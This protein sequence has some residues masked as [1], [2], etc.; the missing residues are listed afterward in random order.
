MAEKK[1]I[2]IAVN[3]DAQQSEQ[4]LDQLAKSL[5]QATNGIQSIVASFSAVGK[6]ID[7]V[8]GQ[9][10]KSLSAVG[11]SLQQVSLNQLDSKVAETTKKVAANADKAKQSIEGVNTV[12]LGQVAKEI[13]G[14]ARNLNTINFDQIKTGLQQVDAGFKVFNAQSIKRIIALGNALR[15]IQG[16]N[17]EQLQ[18]LERFT[19]LLRQ[20]EKALLDVQRLGSTNLILPQ[21]NQQTGKAQ[22]LVDVINI[23]KQLGT[24]SKDLQAQMQGINLQFIK[25]IDK[26]LKSLSPSTVT[27]FKNSLK[28]LNEVLE[29]ASKL[30]FTASTQG[31]GTEKFVAEVQRILNG[32][33]QIQVTPETMEKVRSIGQVMTLI[34]LV[35]RSSL[36]NGSSATPQSVDLQ[37]IINFVKATRSIPKV[38]PDKIQD[39]PTLVGHL[40][41][42]FDRINNLRLGTA[43]TFAQ[44]ADRLKDFNALVTRVKSIS[45]VTPNDYQRIQEVRDSTVL[46][47]DAL[48][49]VNNIVTRFFGASPKAIKIPSINIGKFDEAKADSLNRFVRSLETFSL[50]AARIGGSATAA[51]A[52][53]TAIAGGI[54]ALNEA[55][56]GVTEKRAAGIERLGD[57]IQEMSRGIMAAVNNA[58]AGGLNQAAAEIETSLA[59][60]G[61]A[62]QEYYSKANPRTNDP[63]NTVRQ[64]IDAFQQN[65]RRVRETYVQRNRRSATQTEPEGFLGS[66]IENVNDILPTRGPIVQ[67][68]GT[69]FLLQGAIFGIERA[70]ERLKTS[71]LG[72]NIELE[73]HIISLTTI[74][75]TM[76]KAQEVVRKFAIPFAAQVP[77]FE[78]DQIV[79]TVERLAAE[80]F[81]IGEITG[82]LEAGFNEFTGRF[83]NQ[84]EGSLVKLLGSAAVA[85]G[86]TLDQSTDA[87][88]S[89]IQ[90]RFVK[91]RRFGIDQGTLTQFGF[92]GNRE[93]REGLE[94]SLKQIY[95][96]RFGDLIKAQSK[97]FTG[98]VS[99]IADLLG[100][101]QRTLF[102]GVFRTVSSELQQV[103]DALSS[104]EAAFSLALTTE[105]E[106]A[107]GLEGLL[108]VPRQLAKNLKGLSNVF[109]DI[110]QVMVNTLKFIAEYRYEF[111]VGIFVP[112]A[113]LFNNFLTYMSQRLIESLLNFAGLF[114]KQ[115]K[116]L[117]LPFAKPIQ[118]FREAL[119]G[120]EG[121][122]VN[123]KMTE[124]IVKSSTA[125]GGFTKQLKEVKTLQAGGLFGDLLNG[126]TRLTKGFKGI[127]LGFR[128]LGTAQK[129][130]SVFGQ[131]LRGIP[132]PTKPIVEMFKLLGQAPS[133]FKVLEVAWGHVITNIQR[134]VNGLFDRLFPLFQQLNNSK[135]TDALVNSFRGLEGA[136]QRMGLALS[137][138]SKALDAFWTAGNKTQGMLNALNRS[139]LINGQGIVTAFNGSVLGGW[140]TRLTTF[141]TR[142]NGFVGGFA[143]GIAAAFAGAGAALGRSGFIAQIFN[144]TKALIPLQA[145]SKALQGLSTVASGAFTILSSLLNVVGVALRGGMA[146]AGLAI[147]LAGSAFK[148]AL[149]PAVIDVILALRD[150]NA[151]LQTARTTALKQLIESI[152]TFA[153]AAENA[154]ISLKTAF[155]FFG[156]SEGGGAL[157][158]LKA[159]FNGLTKIANIIQDLQPAITI[160]VDALKA[161]LGFLIEAFAVLIN[162][163]SKVFGFFLPKDL[164]D[165]FNTLTENVRNFGKQLRDTT[166]DLE[167]LARQKI[168][169]AFLTQGF[170]GLRDAGG[171]RGLV[172][173]KG[174]KEEIDKSLAQYSQYA[175]NV[176]KSLNSRFTT[177]ASRDALNRDQGLA[178]QTE[179]TL[180]NALKELQQ[181]DTGKFAQ[182]FFSG[183]SDTIVSES[184]TFAQDNK[185]RNALTQATVALLQETIDLSAAKFKVSRNGQQLGPAEGLDLEALLLQAT[186]EE[187]AKAL[188]EELKKAFS[189]LEKNIKNL[190]TN[191]GVKKA[192]LDALKIDKQAAQQVI[193]EIVNITSAVTPAISNS[194][195]ATNQEIE[196]FAKTTNE[197]ATG[198][199][200]TFQSF[201][202]NISAL[203]QDLFRQSITDAPQENLDA[204]RRS[205]EAQTIKSFKA[206]GE[207]LRELS[208]MRGE[209]DLILQDVQRNQQELTQSSESILVE[210]I[211]SVSKVLSDSGIKQ[212]F[213]TFIQEAI[214]SSTPI[215]SDAMTKITQQLFD[216]VGVVQGDMILK[217][218]ASTLKGVSQAYA[219]S[220]GEIKI[221][222]KNIKKLQETVTNL[223]NIIIKT[224]DEIVRQT[225]TTLA[226]TDKMVKLGQLD[227]KTAFERINAARLLLETNQGLQQNEEAYLKTVEETYRAALDFIGLV[228]RDL[229]VGKALNITG[230]TA[231]L[232]QAAKVYRTI[233]D[234]VSQ[235]PKEA[236]NLD[237]WQDELNNSAKELLDTYN[238]VLD[239]QLQNRL[240]LIE[241]NK[242]L[243]DILR[244]RQ[245][246]AAIPE[247]VGV[248]SF[249]DIEQGAIASIEAA[250]AL[251]AARI[252]AE[253]LSVALEEQ[254][255]TAEQTLEIYQ[256][257]IESVASIGKTMGATGA[258]SE[259]IKDLQE[260]LA[261][262]LLPKIQAIQKGILDTQNRQRETEIN[263]NKEKERALQIIKQQR[264]LEGKMAQDRVSD[265]RAQQRFELAGLKAISGAD[266]SDAITRAFAVDELEALVQQVSS[267]TGR[268]RRETATELLERFREFREKGLL[269]PD[270]I[271]RFANIYKNLRQEFSSTNFAIEDQNEY[272]RLQRELEAV[273]LST[274]DLGNTFN[275]LTTEIESYNT[276]LNKITENSRNFLILFAKALGGQEDPAQTVR[277]S[278]TGDRNTS[279]TVRNLTNASEDQ[280]Y[281]EAF[282]QQTKFNQRET[283][284]GITQS[285]QRPLQTLATEF[286]RT[287]TQLNGAT[288]EMVGAVEKITNN[289]N[290]QQVVAEA[291]ASL[292]NA[293]NDVSQKVKTSQL[294]SAAE[295][296]QFYA[297]LET[298]P[299]EAAT[300]SMLSYAALEE[301]L[302]KAVLSANQQTQPQDNQA[303]LQSLENM[304]FLLS[305]LNQTAAQEKDTTIELSLDPAGL[306]SGTIESIL[307]NKLMEALRFNM[308]ATDIRNE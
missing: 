14:I 163:M 245:R 191:Q 108:P 63:L 117:Q 149:L 225:Q 282:S 119:V 240:E 286:E 84:F 300:E 64:N 183:L 217:D 48:T 279:N 156:E 132:V 272:I 214:Q 107:K 126:F 85:F 123:T 138:G 115:T 262:D 34:D 281:N 203:R 293:L 170:S 18:S 155:G 278:L 129:L 303:M 200:K 233:R 134:S 61:N 45:R 148:F 253:D 53:V 158:F 30:E 159:F 182:S 52:S 62:I 206:R 28:Q 298:N 185:T 166:K 109:Q 25:D 190:D 157:K 177:Q 186:P 58:G 176:Q 94:S 36:I 256:D 284:E 122:R 205:I 152:K 21:A 12:D 261:R 207:A 165:G 72:A 55:T 116:T 269:N 243:A 229:N 197:E 260:D 95:Q 137:N 251:R 236:K 241:V 285:V 187:I 151:G 195:K 86:K 268:A 67:L 68:T 97:T 92:S 246:L 287:A 193:E 128:Q 51:V 49:D 257:Q 171:F 181:G 297:R 213:S 9:I 131:T 113:T 174:Q 102:E 71:V 258:N 35:Q 23:L 143:R 77:F 22:A 130:L 89:A 17:S 1:K 223:S 90:G 252:E 235:L 26:G 73:Q 13:N 291:T 169:S 270:E 302:N 50:A 150:F 57:A 87:F 198:I 20:L 210:G 112:I 196:K 5:T 242:S 147:G 263:L 180:Q 290:A 220:N 189:T 145:I 194:A 70:M 168:T 277:E 227:K 65:S 231:D 173:L 274:I 228:K 249:R 271:Q 10:S 127:S 296:A 82:R 306:T 31:L 43:K 79:A 140:L 83:E 141:F 41:V 304:R 114:N 265:L 33:N 254:L 27:T 98:A 19:T 24:A 301:R 153:S 224:Q 106:F 81:A 307:V 88:I 247:N 44:I 38:D 250:D 142:I 239:K 32:I 275:K 2:D 3:T 8:L 66:G 16:F 60:I 103:A 42:T 294:P 192:L 4:T 91:V 111:A 76:E 56:K 299:L 255:S 248:L 232:Q 110:A 120:L 219:D 172:D 15:S 289:G 215:T 124:Q 78:F 244:T 6:G 37:P 101:I 305:Q 133:R 69:L 40:A 221:G 216:Q 104:F 46:L 125:L 54:K 11:V 292:G 39:L 208:K 211:K 7:G 288:Q 96:L 74:T 179:N 100:N 212:D 264:D 47:V 222:E 121:V 202:S 118:K 80:G 75:G 178:K 154:F 280:L 93:D 135:S 266:P 99:N 273:K 238:S 308:R 167:K 234:V 201:E 164:M 136:I 162:L 146:A 161:G 226:I 237:Q 188:E 139:V 29:L 204:T 144:L 59:R 105:E 199:E 276:R 295:M 267:S 209:A 175:A 283:L 184:K 259:K 160:M 230:M 218:L